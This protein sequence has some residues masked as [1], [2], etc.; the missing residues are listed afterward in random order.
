MI[1]VITIIGKKRHTRKVRTY[2]E[3]DIV[4]NKIGKK[5]IVKI[6]GKRRRRRQSTDF[7]D[8]LIWGD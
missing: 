8:S 1:E 6:I 5:G 2:E 4:K 7:L 3:A